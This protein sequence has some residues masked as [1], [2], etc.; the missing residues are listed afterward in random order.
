MENKE[1]EMLQ[2]LIKSQTE[3]VSTLDRVSTVFAPLTERAK[4]LTDEAKVFLEEDNSTSIIKDG[5]QSFNMNSRV[6]FKLTKYGKS[7]FR[8]FNRMDS[9]EIEE[10]KEEYIED[11]L[12]AFMHDYGTMIIPLKPPIFEE[13]SIF[14]KPL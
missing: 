9:S 10:D 4:R 13:N 14:I 12:W 6:R 2:R 11:Y 5:Y 3:L 8:K 7:I 1:R